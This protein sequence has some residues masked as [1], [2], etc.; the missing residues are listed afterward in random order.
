MPKN[1]PKKHTVTVTLTVLATVEIRAENIPEA[2]AKAS[3]LDYKDALKRRQTEI[4]D[5]ALDEVRGVAG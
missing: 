3:K 5:A 1:Q 4:H 2:Y